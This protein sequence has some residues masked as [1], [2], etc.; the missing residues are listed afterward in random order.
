MPEESCVVARPTHLDVEE[1]AVVVPLRQVKMDLTDS[2]NGSLN[3]TAAVT[4]RT[5]CC[6][7]FV[8]SVF[9]YLSCYASLHHCVSSQQCGRRR[10][11]LS[12]VLACIPRTLLTRYRLEK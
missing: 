2:A 9:F 7:L 5:L 4:K 12:S 3:G 11:V 8:S 10:N 1:A 6:I